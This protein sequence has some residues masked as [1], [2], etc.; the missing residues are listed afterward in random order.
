V[1]TAWKIVHRAAANHMAKR[2]AQAYRRGMVVAQQPV[3]VG[4]FWYVLIAFSPLVLLWLVLR[5]LPLLDA[6]RDRRA[7][8]RR[9]TGPQGY[10][11]ER[12]AADL[13]RL[14]AELI[15]DPHDNYVRRTALFMAY[16]SV[17]RDM[18]ARLEIP[19]ELATA[20]P[21]PELELERLRAEAAIQEAGI[22]LHGPR[23][24]AQ[25]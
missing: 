14:R 1:E 3:L 5:V 2:P 7:A 20:A 24:R 22:S 16:D 19:T 12:L 18:C 11:V 9:S 25:P 15:N 4:V 8:R 23:R 6:I 21:G 10:P 13:R 17:L